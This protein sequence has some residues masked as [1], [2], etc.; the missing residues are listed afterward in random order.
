MVLNT[1]YLDKFWEQVSQK[2]KR[3]GGLKKKNMAER[4]VFN[5]LFELGKEDHD[6]LIYENFLQ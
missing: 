3:K 6:Q 5:L 4:P 1:G 2:K